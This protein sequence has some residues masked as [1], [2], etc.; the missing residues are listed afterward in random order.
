MLIFNENGKLLFR[1]E[2]MK[3]PTLVKT[4]KVNLNS[5]SDIFCKFGVRWRYIHKTNN[6]EMKKILILIL[7]SVF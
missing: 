1:K 7:L 2:K 4:S 3:V 5:Y 6:K